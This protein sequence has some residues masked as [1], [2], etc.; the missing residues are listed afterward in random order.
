MYSNSGFEKFF[1]RYKPESLTNQKAIQAFC[2][3][4]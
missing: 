4:N 1:L 3:R 2:L